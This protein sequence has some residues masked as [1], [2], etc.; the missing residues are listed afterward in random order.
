MTTDNF[1][2]YLQNSQIQTTQTGGHRYSDTSP[3]VFPAL[4]YGNF[5]KGFLEIA[6]ISIMT[7]IGRFTVLALAPWEPLQHRGM[8]IIVAKSVESGK[9]TPML[10]LLGFWWQK[11]TKLHKCKQNLSVDKMAP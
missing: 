7:D 5:I 2:F 1:C 11:C 10:L 6:R 9:E 3:L 4:W 8:Y